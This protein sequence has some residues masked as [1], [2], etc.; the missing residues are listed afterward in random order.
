MA[1]LKS[2]QGNRRQTADQLGISLRTLQY[3]LKELKHDDAV[4]QA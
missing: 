2:C 3:K 4:S 1:T